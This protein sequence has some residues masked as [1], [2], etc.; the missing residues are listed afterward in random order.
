MATKISIMNRAL[1]VL[2]RERIT[3]PTQNEPRARILNEHYNDVRDEVLRGHPWNSAMARALISKESAAPA[4]G[5]SFQY[6]LPTDPYCLRAV[7]LHNYEGEF[8]VE[9][10]KLLTNAASPIG[11]HYIKRL[12]TP[13][14]MDPLLAR[15]VSY[16]LAIETWTKL[17]ED[18]KSL[19]RALRRFE[20]TLATARSTDSQ[21][22]WVDEFWGDE[23]LESREE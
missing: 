23:F 12:T 6:P 13:A 18:G 11:L 2:G 22:G 19:D 7:K 20:G 17:A 14:E 5:F 21:E 9:G 4:F 3:G 16:A 1:V 10:R 8:R 15:A